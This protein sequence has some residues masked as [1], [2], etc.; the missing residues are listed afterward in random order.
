MDLEER[1]S[2]WKKFRKFI[3]KRTNE[4]FDNTLNQKGQCG[5]I[6]FDH[7]AKELRITVQKD[8]R[9][10]QTQ[11]EDVKLLS[12]G[13]RSF[14]TLSLLIAIGDSIECPFRVMDEFDVFMDAVSRKVALDQLI[15]QGRKHKNRQF[16]FITPQDLSTV[17]P[18]PD[19][20]KTGLKIIKLRDPDRVVEG[21][22]GG[23]VERHQV[24]R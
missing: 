22:E 11:I 20:L 19:F 1:L 15:V 9:D 3:S 17:T 21:Q 6:K 14:V 18:E 12:G 10:L 16:I 23:E 13:E 4:E 7:R 5:E 8:N 2:K 24:W